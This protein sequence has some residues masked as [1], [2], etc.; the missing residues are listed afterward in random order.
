LAGHDY[1]QLSFGIA[2]VDED[3]S[4]DSLSGAGWRNQER[5]RRQIMVFHNLVPIAFDR[6]LKPRYPLVILIANKKKLFAQTAGIVQDQQMIRTSP[7]QGRAQ[8]A[9]EAVVDSRH[10]IS[11]LAADLAH[12]SRSCR[13]GAV[14]K[15]C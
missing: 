3:W 13:A 15:T 4:S 1:A 6:E 10:H 2:L 12:A 14:S 5:D 9:F 11:C 8:F 7:S